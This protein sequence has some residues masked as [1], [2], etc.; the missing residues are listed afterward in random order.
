MPE[1]PK[2]PGRSFAS[3]LK[4]TEIEWES[5]MAYEMESCRSYRDEDW[6]LVLR[7][8]PAG[9]SELY[10]MNEDPFERFNLFGQ[11]EYAEVQA[12]MKIE[13]NAFFEDYVDPE[14][15]IW[16]GGRSKAKRLV[17]PTP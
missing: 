9:P 3:L 14:Y 10:D 2:S 1:E 11:P 13:L 12:G 17:P 5:R 7:K 15:D 8:S 6:K 4:G 16:N